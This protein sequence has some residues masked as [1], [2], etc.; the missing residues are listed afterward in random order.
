MVLKLSLLLLSSTDN[1]I[2]KNKCREW[3]GYKLPVKMTINTST[4]MSGKRLRDR[5]GGNGQNFVEGIW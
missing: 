3:L 1:I 4:T 2:G 5:Y